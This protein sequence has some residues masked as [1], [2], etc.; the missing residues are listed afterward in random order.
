MGSVKTIE[1][2]ASQTLHKKTCSG[3]WRIS[4]IERVT[5]DD[6]LMLVSMEM[7]LGGSRRR[8]AASQNPYLWTVGGSHREPTQKS[9]GW[10]QTQDLTAV[11]QQ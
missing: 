6:L 10:T 8:E 4:D 3:L 9:S 1:S 11:R 5:T 7:G 2:A